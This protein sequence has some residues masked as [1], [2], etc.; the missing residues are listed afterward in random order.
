MFYLILGA[1]FLVMH[2]IVNQIPVIEF[3]TFQVEAITELFI[4][5][6]K[7]SFFIPWS[8]VIICM[9]LIGAYYAALF[10]TKLVNWL[11]HRLPV[12]G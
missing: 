12:I 11:I 2:T 9:S 10:T 5:L 3:S 7:S 1:I 8:T 4:L 6:R